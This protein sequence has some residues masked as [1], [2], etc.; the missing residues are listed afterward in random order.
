MSV[1]WRFDLKNFNQ[2]PETLSAI[3]EGLNDLSPFFKKFFVPAYLQTMQFQFETEGGLTGFWDGLD[4]TYERWKNERF[5]G[6]LILQRTRRLVR[7]F[8][9]GGR[10]KD[11]SVQYGPRSAVIRTMVPYAFW[12]NQTRKIMVPPRRLSKTK[13]KNLLEGYVQ[14][15]IRRGT[16]RRFSTAEKGRGGDGGFLITS[17]R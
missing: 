14:D 5:P 2:L 9:P 1:R 3:V 11:L 7:S 10:S 13:Y 17:G 15:L 8:S 12:V 4:P 16:T 6:R